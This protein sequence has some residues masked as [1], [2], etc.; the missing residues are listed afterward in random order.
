M[1]KKR[2]SAVRV[3]GY[4]NFDDLTDDDPRFIAIGIGGWPGFLR[5]N[6]YWFG[7]SRRFDSRN[8]L[9]TV[10]SASGLRWYGESKTD[11]HTDSVENETRI[12]RH[13]D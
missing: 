3:Q 12:T 11:G 6:Q 8:L 7:I 4:V 5:S 2:R 9:L 10:L 1:R 13:I